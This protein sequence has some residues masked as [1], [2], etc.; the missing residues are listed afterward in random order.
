MATAGAYD[1]G[2]QPK[3]DKDPTKQIQWQIQKAIAGLWDGI[4]GAIEAAVNAVKEW[5][6]GLFGFIGDVIDWI[7]PGEIIE[8]ILQALTGMSTVEVLDLLINNPLGFLPT[9]LVNFIKNGLLGKHS[10]LNAFNIF[11]LLQSWNL[12]FLSIGSLT[13]KQPNILVAPGFS[14]EDSIDEAGN[15]WVWDPDDGRTDP[16]CARVDVVDAIQQILQS[17]P[18]PVAEGQKI[19]SHIW[20][21]WQG[22]TYT[23]T[24]P[25]LVDLVR[26]D[27]NGIE[28][29][30]TTLKTIV[31]P[32]T[33]SGGNWFQID[34]PEYEIPSGNT[35]QI[36]WQLR[37][38]E[39][40]TG[41]SV[42][43]DDAELKKV[44][45]SIPQNW[46]LNLVP[47][48]GGIRDWIQDVI[49]G[50]I[51]AIRGIPFV[52]G[53]IA[54]LLLYITGWKEDTDSTAGTATDAYIGLGVTQKI[55]TATA[56]GQ[57]LPD[58][59]VTLPQDDEVMVA[60]QAQTQVIVA[61]G[62][63]IDAL[64]TQLTSEGNAGVSGMDDFE[65]DA[66]ADLAT[67]GKWAKFILEGTDPKMKTDGHNATAENNGT[68]IYRFTGEGQHTLTDYQKVT[69]TVASKLVYP[70]FNDG[71]RPHQA[72]VCRMSDDGTKWVRAYWNNIR[73]LVVDY[74]N[75]A[76]SGNL[77]VS[78]AD[79]ISPPGPG[80]NLS[81]EPGVGQSGLRHFRI[82]RG[83]TPIR[84]VIDTDNLTYVGADARGH[85]VGMRIHSG[86]GP[87][88]FTQY[89]A[90]DNA[91][92]PVPGTY[93]KVFRAASGGITLPRAAD[94]PASVMDTIFAQSGIEWLDGV[95]TCTKSG[96]YA[97]KLRV[98]NSGRL[99]IGNNSPSIIAV[100][101]DGV[102]W[103]DGISHAGAIGGAGADG[104][105]PYPAE[106]NALNG[107][108]DL[109]LHVG[110]QVSFYLVSNQTSNISAVGG[111]LG[112]E[113]FLT[114]ARY[115]G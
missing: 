87:G 18:I 60:L 75:G 20:V 19:K 17:V 58:G 4:I 82:W 47:D 3:A 72:A 5:V 114:M 42:W 54:N 34:C 41:G 76:A 16:G 44:N 86:F 36:L 78:A 63:Q 94:F 74:R 52:G 70:R 80:E 100:K 90:V 46:V 66:V 102:R 30:K 67:T 53:S 49:D 88:A 96:I 27:E 68:T 55:I 62:A 81:I 12:P 101:I 45:T 22:L 106:F 85:G 51:S 92:A 91:P 59:T 56:Q 1:G 7:N 105:N 110:Q 35:A 104:T 111:P 40:A 93:L 37:V 107:D 14:L 65:Y 84:T 32:A 109:P 13:N 113:T 103:E 25:I 2:L 29:S 115:G 8:R 23:G 98:K 69:A 71:R 24:N 9:I 57:P 11:G 89:T 43:W 33:S 83:N 97:T 31:N 77:Y 38:Q 28:I 112:N 6:M 10:P 39:T 50:I 26:L 95:A 108:W 48:L 73:Q 15:G 61:Q 99:P 79:S 21:K 64:Q